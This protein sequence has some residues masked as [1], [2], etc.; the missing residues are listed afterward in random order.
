MASLLIFSWSGVWPYIKL[1]FVSE[2]L[3]RLHAMLRCLHFRH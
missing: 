2:R 3:S 1:V